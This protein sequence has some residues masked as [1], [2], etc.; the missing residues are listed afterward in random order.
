MTH[1]EQNAIKAALK[2]LDTLAQIFNDDN[3]PSLVRDAAYASTQDVIDDLA[4]YGFLYRVSIVHHRMIILDA[5]DP[6]HIEIPA[7]PEHKTYQERAP[8]HY[9]SSTYRS[10]W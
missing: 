7:Q 4:G 5:L 8:R 3:L 1:G 2:R 6:Y 10:S 9:G